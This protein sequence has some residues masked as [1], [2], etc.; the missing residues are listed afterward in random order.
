MLFCFFLLGFPQWAEL[1]GRARDF[2]LSDGDREGLYECCYSGVWA[3]W[4]WWWERL[5]WRALLVG[6]KSRN[7]LVNRRTRK[8]ETTSGEWMEKVMV[9]AWQWMSWAAGTLCVTCHLTDTALLDRHALSNFVQTRR[10][11][12]VTLTKGKNPQM[13][14]CCSN[15]GL[16]FEKGSCLT[17]V[18]TVYQKWIFTSSRCL[19]SG[20]SLIAN[21]I[22]TGSQSHQQQRAHFNFWVAECHAFYPNLSC[23]FLS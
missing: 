14:K 22:V 3:V 12:L 16:A 2:S 5:V 23:F 1:S 21:E 19:T 7:R 20:Y 17:P 4:S 8:A 10:G 9:V 18:Q 15:A 11:V 6:N 13:A